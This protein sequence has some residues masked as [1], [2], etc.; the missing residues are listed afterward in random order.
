MFQLEHL[1][2]FSV[3]SLSF[4]LLCRS[5]ALSM[6]PSRTQLLRLLIIIVSIITTQFKYNDFLQQRREGEHTLFAMAILL[7]KLVSNYNSNINFRL[8]F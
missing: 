8:L 1:N 7:T 2:F 6:Q 4:C 5:L 3:F